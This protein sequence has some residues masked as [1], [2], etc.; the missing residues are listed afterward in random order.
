MVFQLEKITT[1][2][3][4][5]L[6]SWYFY[7]FYMVGNKFSHILGQIHSIGGDGR[8]NCQHVLII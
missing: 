5:R 4:F 2:K 8:N 6:S 1:S 3:G 7:L